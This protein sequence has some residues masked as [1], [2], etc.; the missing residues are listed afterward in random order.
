MNAAMRADL[1][2]T[3]PLAGLPVQ[4]APSKVKVLH[5]ITKYTT[6]A[7]GNTFL[8][9]IGMDP[10]RYEVWVAAS[11]VSEFWDR[12]KQAGVRTVRFARLRETISPL[13]DLIVLA[14][15]IRLMRRERFTI[16]HTHTAKAGFVG[17]VAAW[18]C[19]TPVVVHTFHAFSFHDFMGAGRYRAYLSLER[20][21][22]RF[23]DSYIAV[24]PRLAREAVEHRVAPPGRVS[25][26]P[27]AV[28]LDQIP[29]TRMPWLR[30]ELG[31]E[32]PG[33]LIGTVGR[34]SPQ[35]APLDFVR[36]AKRVAETRPD[37]RFVMVGDGPL[38]D[39]ARAEAARLGVDIAFPGF[40]TDAARLTSAFDVFVMPSL[41]EGL[42]RSLTE[43][44][45]SGRPLVA[46]AVNAVTDLV[47]PGVTGL[48]A[49]PA[50]PDAVAGCV[51]WLLE[52]PDDAERMGL[53]AQA[54]VRSLFTPARMCEALDRVYRNLLGTHE[55]GSD[56]HAG[57]PAT[58]AAV[59]DLTD[60]ALRNRS[61]AELAT[62]GAR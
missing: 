22:R 8:S 31:I 60:A 61:R 36:M 37:A 59:V 51:V 38:L 18:A 30:T 26:I 3:A 10:E 56:D 34:I 48:V 45:A 9:A 40:L 17:R 49:P 57:A 24:A 62:N 43:A 35:K 12:T 29:E 6:G 33:P 15:L 44:M 2:V 28:E 7:G 52:H 14:Q 46:S 54:T 55:L 4:P 23:T 11:P 39:D 41:Y 27:S 5:F 32:G 47:H 20:L 1:S 25:V 42:G 50:D 58:A 19:G 13:D 16:V 53:Q 21:M